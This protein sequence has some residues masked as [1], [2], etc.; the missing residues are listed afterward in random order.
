[1][2]CL[3]AGTWSGQTFTAKNNDVFVGDTGGGTILDGSGMPA[4]SMLTNG[5][6]GNGN[7]SVTGVTLYY[8]T[9]QNYAKDCYNANWASGTENWMTQLNISQGWT[10]YDSVFQNSGGTGV[11][12]CDG[13]QIFNSRMLYNGHSGVACGGDGTVIEG[14]EIAYNNQNGDNIYDDVGG[15]KFCDV[16]NIQ[17]LNNYVHDNKADGI[18]ADCRGTNWLIQGNTVINNVGNGIMYE[19]S[20]GFTITNNVA[21]GNQQWQIMI[22]NSGSGTISNNNITETGSGSGPLNM[23]NFCDNGAIVSQRITNVTVSNNTVTFLG[24]G[25]PT[26][27][28]AT[29]YGISTCSGADVAASGDSMQGDSFYYDYSGN[30]ANDGHFGWSVQAG[31]NPD[32]GTYPLSGLQGTYGQET[33]ATL[34]LGQSGQ[35]IGCKQVGCTGSGAP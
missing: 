4:C 23:Q 35:L 8:L 7:P 32:Y 31:N 5:R 10:V 15:L 6:D 18:W 3:P 2:F 26:G 29:Q 16:N 20:T 1:M 13:G 22:A 24:L 21:Y 19:I 12:A 34:T 17:I 25:A 28:G 30:S 9:V 14:N 27:G 11:G 33:N